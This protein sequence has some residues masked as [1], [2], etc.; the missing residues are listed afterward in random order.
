MNVGALALAGVPPHGLGA[1]ARDVIEPDPF[2]FIAI[3]AGRSDV[4]QQA[5]AV[6]AAGRELWLY[7]TPGAF[8][9]ANWRATLAR[10]RVLV[11]QLGAVGYIADFE[12]LWPGLSRSSRQRDLAA[13]GAELAGDATNM[14]V[15]FTSYPLFPDLE[16]L[17]AAAGAGVFGV[18]Q[19]YH[20]AHASSFAAWW[21]HW[22]DRFTNNIPAIAAW[23]ADGTQ[24]TAEGYRA[25]LRALPHASGAIVWQGTGRLPSYIRR[26]LAS[27]EPG[28]SLV[29]TITQCLEA[30]VV[31]PMG[32]VLAVLL[33]VVLFVA[34][35]ASGVRLA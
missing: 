30:W 32:A 2:R 6:R 35:W 22:Q 26:E 27:Y 8:T 5:A 34:A 21:A 10:L 13:A 7:Q 3:N 4:A 18:P 24:Q 31:R 17:A 11:P 28:G 19:I 9:P 20:G 25:Y 33:V 14:R 16:V 29:G 1:F 23:A 15:G 12:D